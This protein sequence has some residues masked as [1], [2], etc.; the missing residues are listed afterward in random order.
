M[1]SEKSSLG[2]RRAGRSN[3]NLNHD[4]ISANDDNDDQWDYYDFTSG[5]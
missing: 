4:D 1:K 5:Q 2:T 3:N